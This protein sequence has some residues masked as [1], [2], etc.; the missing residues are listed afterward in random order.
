MVLFSFSGWLKAMSRK[1]GVPGGAPRRGQR[2]PGRRCL[3]RLEALEDR[4][5]PAVL[6]VNTL[7][8][9]A[10]ADNALS[11]REAVAAVNSGS[12][13][14]L[15]TAEQMQVAGT[16]GSNDTIQFD[17]GL[18]GGTLTLTGGA[19]NLTRNVSVTGPGAAGLTLSG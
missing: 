19:L 15:N 17:P 9:Q 12:T 1:S 18:A 11:L 3:P 8:D 13:S 5:V 2:P 14:A 4:L 10:T 6:T 16:L 7:A